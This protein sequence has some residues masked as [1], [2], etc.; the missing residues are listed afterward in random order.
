VVRDTTREVE[1]ALTVTKKTPVS[2]DVVELVL[3]DASGGNLPE[4]TPGCHIDL[5]LGERL[6][7]QYSLCGDPADKSSWRVAVLRGRESRGGSTYVHDTLT[8]GSTVHVRGPRN[9][10]PFEKMA[11]YIFIAGGIGI[12]PLLPMMAAAENSGAEWRLLYGGRTRSTMAYADT[13]ARYGE[14]AVIRP[15]DEYGL[16]D[17]PSWLEQPLEDTL[18]YCCGPE[19]L[20]LAAEEHCAHWPSGSL[21]V[22]HFTPKTVGAPADQGS[23]E[24]ELALSGITVTVPPDKSILRAV[25]EAGVRPP[26]SCEQGTCGTCETEVISGTPDHRDSLLTDEERAEGKTMMICVSRAACP[27]L[28]LAL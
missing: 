15:Q 24:V 1:L 28:L 3:S 22:E 5:V 20:L 26:C 18:V 8:E 14:K 23:F 16:L 2:Q 11:R 13:I 7:R 10:F 12:T 19:P 9:T 25:E 21:R 27:R 6:I 17:L 4:W